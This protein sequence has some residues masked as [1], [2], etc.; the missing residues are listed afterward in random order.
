MR[1]IE[2]ADKVSGRAKYAC[3][4]R[5]D[6]QLQARVLRSPLPHARIRRID[7][8]RAQALPGVHAVLCSANA[9]GIEWYENSRLFDYTL[10]F[11]GDEVAAVAAESDEIAEDALRLI[12]VDYEAAAFGVGLDDGARGKAQVKRRGDVARGLREAEVVIDQTY[13]TQTAL[14]NALEPHGCTAAWEGGTLVLY[15]STQ[16][17][18]AVRDEVADNLSLS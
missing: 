1:R 8:S 14:H 15:E 16:G 9:P 3:D 13:S 17:I 6:G 5:L 11:I 18:H 2:G 10:R 7:I 4:V 12:E